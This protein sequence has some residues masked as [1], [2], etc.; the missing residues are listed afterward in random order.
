MAQGRRA[1]CITSTRGFG[2]E[3]GTG[4]RRRNAIVKLIEIRSFSLE[5]HPAPELKIN[6]LA[7]ANDPDNVVKQFNLT[8]PPARPANWQPVQRMG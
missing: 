4:W 1:A 7:L 2:I 8:M 5:N 3:R 6:N